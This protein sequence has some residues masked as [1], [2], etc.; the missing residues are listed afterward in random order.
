MRSKIL[1]LFELI[2]RAD[3][4]RRSGQRL[5][6]TNGCFDLLHVGHVRYLQEARQLGDFLV[7]AVNGDQSVHC[8]KGEGRPLNGEQDR[9]EVVAALACVD[10]VTIFSEPRVTEVI[11]ALRPAIYVK[12]GDYTLDT[13]NPEEVA[14]LKEAGAEIRTVALVPGKSTSGMIERLRK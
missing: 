5:V 7:V 8:L 12:G 3:D 4:L 9:A 14:A 13:L 10:Y 6:L 11:K 1:P 2:R